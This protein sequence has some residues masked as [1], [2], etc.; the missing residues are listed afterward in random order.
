MTTWPE[1]G[2]ERIDS[3]WEM[4]SRASRPPTP[5]PTRVCGWGLETQVGEA[6]DE[7]EVTVPIDI[8]A[9]MI[10]ILWMRVFSPPAKGLPLWKWLYWSVFLNFSAR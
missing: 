7:N 2:S 9:L 1:V 5:P 4:R 6:S 3:S 10:I 8:D